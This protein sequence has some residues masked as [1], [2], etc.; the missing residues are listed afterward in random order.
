MAWTGDANARC[1][2]E[3]E[4][5]AKLAQQVTIYRDSFGIPHV[6]GKT[7][8]AAVFGVMYALAEDALPLI[9]MGIVG[10]IGRRSEVVG[11]EALSSDLLMRALE[12]QRHSIEEYRRSGRRMRTV[13]QAYA[14]GLNHFL[15]CNPRVRPMLISRFEPWHMFATPRQAY[16]A[17]FAGRITGIDGSALT[18]N[19]AEPD[20][21]G[22]NFWLLGPSRTRSGKAMIFINPHVPVATSLERHI[23]SD[24]GWNVQGNSRLG[25]P[26][27]TLGHTPTHAWGLTVN[28]PDI[29]DLWF[30]RFDHP[31]DR[32]SYRYGSAWRR[33]VEWT[34]TIRVRIGSRLVDRQHTFRKTHHG[35][36]VGEKDGRPLALRIARFAE[37]GLNR[38]FYEMSRAR[39][40]T[41]FRR[42]VGRLGVSFH[43]IGYADAQGNIWYLY[44]AAIPR[45][46]PK[47]DWA[48]PV[49]GS[50]PAT[51]WRGYHSLSELPQVLNPRSGWI[52]NT[53]SSPFLVTAAEENPSAADFPA[54]MVHEGGP[55]T[56][57]R[58]VE[59]SGENPRLR[60]SRRILTGR[61]R[62]S[63]AEFAD[64]AMS[65]R[66]YEADIDLPLLEAEL[67]QLTRQDAPRAARLKPV[68]AE[69]RAWDRTASVE[70]VAMTLYS[71]WKR[72]RLRQVAV[73]A[74]AAW[75]AVAALEDALGVIERDWGTWRVAWGEINRVQRPLDPISPTFS[76][77]RSSLPG[78][79]A[80]G[81]TGAIL[82]MDAIR[83]EGQK[84]RY[85]A[86]GNSYVSVVELGRPVRALASLALGQSSDPKSPH[87]DDQARL[88][89]LGGFRTVST[90]LAQVKANSQIA[91]RPG[92]RSE[93]R[94]R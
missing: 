74:P 60:A 61:D 41:Q 80:P 1:I 17:E 66:A 33:A 2:Q 58:G 24:E 48:A 19:T 7:D 16:L 54:Y 10:A 29:A 65:R 92:R 91:Y 76:D 8:E 21:Q 39:S 37:G 38:Q 84:R 68:M 81:A 12:T 94:E 88:F 44:A 30:E 28:Y 62:F 35:P 40:L 43:N 67:A 32:L 13:A 23:I 93:A 14:E 75:A 51:E 45:R 4:R 72:Q 25:G 42:S 73:G 56:R 9:E 77:A 20:N 79:G 70:S 59:A 87:F 27:P 90:T 26:F 53:N 55:I 83:V 63:F 57:L 69:L 3:T 22:S 50:N 89:A 18:A 52:A 15:A 64:A 36:I 46:D 78:L 31:T 71:F 82:T 85:V 5:A 49:D 11:K 34:E 6:H 47:F 86:F